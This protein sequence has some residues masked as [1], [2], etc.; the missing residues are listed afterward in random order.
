MN[1]IPLPSL[2]L[3][4]DTYDY[5]PDTGVF[6]RKDNGHI[7]TLTKGQKYLKVIFQGKSYKVHRLAYYI[8]TG[9]DPKDLFIDHID[10]NPTNNR[11]SNLRLVDRVEQNC[12]RSI[13]VVLTHDGLSLNMSQW[14]ERL[15]CNPKTI[16]FRLN[17]GWSVADAVTVPAKLGNRIKRKLEVIK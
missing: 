13:A 7:Y 16:A 11:F 10:R 5:N 12:N 9:V 14:A 3:L 6:S 4:R 8:H 1:H 17:A 2:S 15:G